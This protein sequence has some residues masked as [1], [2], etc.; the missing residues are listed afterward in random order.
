MPD[1]ALPLNWDRR[2]WIGVGI[3]LLV[4]LVLAVLPNPQA[5]VDN[6]VPDRP[7]V[8]DDAADTVG[9]ITEDIAQDTTLTDEERENLLQQLD[10]TSE[11]LDQANVSPQEALR[12][13]DG[14]ARQT[15]SSRRTISTGRY[16]SS[17]RR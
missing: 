10:E 11:V 6:S 3:V 12:Q 2:A 14:Y 5:A 4:L 13:P 17:S 1:E 7:A 9:D 8:F 15:Y 16:S